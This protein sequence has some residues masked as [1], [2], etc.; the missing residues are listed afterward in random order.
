MGNGLGFKNHGYMI[1]EDNAVSN[2]STR[3]MK[4]INLKDCLTE[5]VIIRLHK[6]YP[7]T[8]NRFS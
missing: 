3:E 8:V 1:L 2:Y 4:L 6:N 7:T 5:Y